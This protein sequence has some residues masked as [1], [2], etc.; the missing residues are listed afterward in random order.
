MKIKHLQQLLQLICLYVVVILLPFADVSHVS[1]VI[2]CLFVVWRLF[3]GILCLV[4]CRFVVF[5]YHFVVWGLMLFLVVALFISESERVLS[6]VVT[7]LC[8]HLS[9]CGEVSL[10]NLFIA[11]HPQKPFRD[12]Y[13]VYRMQP[14]AFLGHLLYIFVLVWMDFFS[15]FVVI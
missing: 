7:S 14:R 2:L 3:M 5:L 15:L 13:R 4:L 12:L 8:G 1:V 6:V 11:Q 10:S 9:L